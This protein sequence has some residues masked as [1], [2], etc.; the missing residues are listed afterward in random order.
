MGRRIIVW[1]LGI[2]GM[3]NA[4]EARLARQIKPREMDKVIGLTGLVMKAGPTWHAKLA[5][6][7]RPGGL[8]RLGRM[9]R[10]G[11]LAVLAGLMLLTAGCGRKQVDEKVMMERPGD[12][13]ALT[14]IV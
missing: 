2:L 3:R 9:A 8:V 7:T 10:V 4:K 13:S 1:R 14:D 11:R 12:I 6:Q 5:M